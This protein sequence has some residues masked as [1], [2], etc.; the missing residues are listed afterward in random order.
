AGAAYLDVAPRV[1]RL[2]R[3]VPIPEL[4]FRLPGRV[5]DPAALSRLAVDY[6]LTNPFNRVLSAV[7]VD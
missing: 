5:A 3:D 4:D 7:G 6:G 1:V 2:A